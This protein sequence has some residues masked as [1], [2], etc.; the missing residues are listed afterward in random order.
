[1][2]MNDDKLRARM[3]EAAR[4]SARLYSREI[5]VGNFLRLIGPLS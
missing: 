2:L 3:A 1:M 5:F 4:E